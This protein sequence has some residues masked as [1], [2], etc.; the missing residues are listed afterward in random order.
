MKNHV[1][2]LE[3]FRELHRKEK[4]A[5]L[6]LAGDGEEYGQIQQ[7]VREYGLQECVLM[8]GRREDLPR[9]YQAMDV[10]VL[11]SHFEGLS[12][13]S[14]EAQSAGL[15]CILSDKVPPEAKIS[16][17]CYYLSL[18]KGAEQWAKEILKHK[19]YNRE[20][21]EI[22]A[23]ESLFDYKKQADMLRNIVS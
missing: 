21:A 8:L 12:I 17:E 11:P 22:T 14:L 6:M 20:K 19:N 2:L 15:C 7:K 3:V 13:V 23:D 4:R 10:F 5:V 9:L 16:S 18:N 1:F